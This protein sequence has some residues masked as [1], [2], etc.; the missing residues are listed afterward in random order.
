MNFPIAAIDGVFAA[1]GSTQMSVLSMKGCV[2]RSLYLQGFHK[3]NRHHGR[4][5][6]TPAETGQGDLFRS[7]VSNG[8]AAF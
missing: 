3:T 1:V 8:Y 5:P 7:I 6:Q 2:E 4:D